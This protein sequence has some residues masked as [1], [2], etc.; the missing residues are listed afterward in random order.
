ME[1]QAK[2]SVQYYFRL[3]HRDI[4]F[5]VLGM[6]IVYALSGI[7]LVNRDTNFLKSQRQVELQLSPNIPE[8]DLGT[9]LHLRDFKVTKTEGD[10]IYFGNNGTY[11]K[12]TGV[13][14][15]TNQALPAFMDKL[16]N[17]HKASS[18]SAI[19]LFSLI[20]GIALL[21]LAISSFWMFKANSK[22][23][24]RGMIFAGSG[25]IIVVILL[26]V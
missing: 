11:N 1:T 22:N 17:L 8:S 15:Y 26:I 14:N 12:T 9:A 21:F 24:K 20:Y 6:T 3:L 10:L 13:A 19:H 5:L 16:T 18:K 4:G 23:F 2:K 7:V 25:I